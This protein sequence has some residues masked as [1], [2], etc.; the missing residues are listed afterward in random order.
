LHISDE[1]GKLIYNGPMN[2]KDF[3]GAS[4]GSF[5]VDHCKI[6]KDIIKPNMKYIGIG[7]YGKEIGTAP[8][9]SGRRQMGNRRLLVAR[10]TNYGIVKI[11][12]K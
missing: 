12:G 4:E 10:L 9:D 3:V 5:V 6:N 11:P 7:F 1:D 2:K 8:A